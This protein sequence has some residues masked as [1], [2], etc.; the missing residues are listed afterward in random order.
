[1]PCHKLSTLLANLVL[2]MELVD[3]APRTRWGNRIVKD[4]LGHKRPPG[5]RPRMRMR[6]AFIRRGYIHRAGRR[7]G[8]IHWTGCQ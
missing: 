4:V 5:R 6:N 3:N 8:H 2:T 7:R 1:M